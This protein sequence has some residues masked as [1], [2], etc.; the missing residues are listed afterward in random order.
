MKVRFYEFPILYSET[1]FFIGNRS[2]ITGFT[3][4][5]TTPLINGRV[6]IKADWFNIYCAPRMRGSS[7]SRRWEEGKPE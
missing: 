7:A 5:K 2:F 6:D 4:E 1:C 3:K